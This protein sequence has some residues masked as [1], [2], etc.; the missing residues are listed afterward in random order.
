LSSGGTPLITAIFPDIKCGTTLAF[1][2]DLPIGSF[3]CGTYS[4][5]FSGTTYN[6][7]GT[8]TGTFDTTNAYTVTCG[9]SVPEFGLSAVA[10]AGVS[11][12]ALLAL[13]KRALSLRI[14][15]I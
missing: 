6:V 12:V 13:R 2:V 14:Q 11:L 7:D 3:T 8:E 9:T 10:V 15:S 4:A 1:P 5:E